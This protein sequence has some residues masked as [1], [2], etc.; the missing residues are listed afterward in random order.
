[1]AVGNHDTAVSG[2]GEA[3]DAARRLGDDHETARA[4]GNLGLILDRPAKAE[5]AR[6]AYTESLEIR[7]SLGDQRRLGVVFANLGSFELAQGDLGLA[8][9]HSERA[10]AIAETL[11]DPYEQGNIL[12]NL[13]LVHMLDG[14]VTAASARC[15]E[16]VRLAE[17]RHNQPG[18]GYGLLGMALCRSAAGEP[19]VAARLHGCSDRILSD[20]GLVPQQFDRRQR[21][22]DQAALRRLL[23]DQGFE[24]AHR[25]GRALSDAERIALATAPPAPA[26]GR[27]GGEKQPSRHLYRDS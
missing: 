21:D 25:E 3:V 24:E 8:R 7:G 10:L 18:M 6:A 4:L 20:L 22:D 2:A 27:V 13:A 12:F 16:A 5:R 15:E 19:L 17:R 11:D 23:G 9:A 26:A 1:M 14:D